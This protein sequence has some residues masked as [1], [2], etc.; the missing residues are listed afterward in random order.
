[1]EQGVDGAPKIGSPHPA[2]RQLCIQTGSVPS[3]DNLPEA[4]RRSAFATHMQN[5]D[6]GVV[7]SDAFAVCM[8]PPEAVCV[9]IRG[10]ADREHIQHAL[11]LIAEALQHAAVECAG[12]GLNVCRRKPELR[13]F[14]V[15]YAK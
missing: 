15:K 8:T 6:V 12:A 9:C 10:V 3:V 14:V 7:A 5:S 4:W 13:N 2:A 1:M 11:E